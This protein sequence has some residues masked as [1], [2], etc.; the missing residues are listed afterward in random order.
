MELLPGTLAT[1]MHVQD[2]EHVFW[3]LD[4]QNTQTIY[5]CTTIPLLVVGRTEQGNYL[6]L[7][8]KFGLIE[9]DKN[10]LDHV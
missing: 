3:N 6:V 5:C 2:E 8:P 7:H 10:R 4:R 1:C 9:A